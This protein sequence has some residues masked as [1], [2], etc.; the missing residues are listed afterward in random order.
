ML[1]TVREFALEALA[2]SGETPAVAAVHAAYVR[3]LA[4]RAE[5]ELLGPR[6]WHWMSRLD[7]ELGNLRAAI[8]WALEHDIET[9]LR[10]AAAL[11]P[12]LGWHQPA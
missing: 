1:E 12:Y 2:M 8:A 5:L 6:E 3:D 11:W 10:I 9:A 4:V 7:A